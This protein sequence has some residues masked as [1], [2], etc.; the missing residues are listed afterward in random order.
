MVIH[1]KTRNGK[2]RGQMTFSGM[3]VCE[4]RIYVA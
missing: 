3:C 4:D 2:R 1:Y